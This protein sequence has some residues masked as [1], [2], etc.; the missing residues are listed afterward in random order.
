MS[1]AAIR[2]AL[3][4]ALA[5]IDPALATASENAPFTPV[6]GAPFQ[7]VYLLPARP[8]NPEIG[9]GYTERGLFQINLYYPKDRGSKEAL[10]RAALIR[11]KF[12][13]AASFASGGVT[14]NITATPEVAPARIED[15][16]YMVPVKVRWQS[17]IA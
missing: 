11:T 6:A 12:P 1:L 4:T 16:R 10:V 2:S 15:D 5:E 7:A 9:P 17:R 13:F 8:D 14:V 3:E